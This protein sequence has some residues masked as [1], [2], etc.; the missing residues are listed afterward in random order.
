ML[1]D[2]KYNAVFLDIDG[3]IN[4]ENTLEDCDAPIRIDG[5]LFEKLAEFVKANDLVIIL[6]SDWKDF[7]QK[8]GEKQNR[9]SAFLN[10]A[11]SCEGLA[12][13]DK[14]DGYDL[15]RG[16]Y[17]NKYLKEHK[18]L[19]KFVIFDD[20]ESDYKEENLLDNLVYINRKYGLTD[21]D[22][23]MAYRILNK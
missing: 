12:I 15:Q 19:D 10:Y 4:N 23:E 22:E 14:I 21:E 17:I 20:I 7:W 1:N 9:V 13:E 5:L 11:F 6:I 3:V 2:K 16:K 18:N 8:E